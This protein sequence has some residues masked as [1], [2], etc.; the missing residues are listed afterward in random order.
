[1]E[2]TIKAK[3]ITTSC[4]NHQ[5]VVRKSSIIHLNGVSEALWEHLWPISVPKV[6]PRAI[7]QYFVKPAWVVYGV[8]FLSKTDE[9]MFWIYLR[10]HFK[11]FGKLFL[12]GF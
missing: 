4:P 5:H 6:S 3:T 8:C 12:V 7:L 10:S 1:M 9:C 11:P 2:A